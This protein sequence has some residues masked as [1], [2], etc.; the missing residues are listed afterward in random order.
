MTSIS[1]IAK[2]DANITEKKEFSPRWVH[3]LDPDQDKTAL[4]KEATDPHPRGRLANFRLEALQ[5]MMEIDLS[6]SENKTLLEIFDEFQS[7]SVDNLHLCMMLSLDQD[8][9]A[10]PKYQNSFRKKCIE[11]AELIRRDELFKTLKINHEKIKSCAD[12]KRTLQVLLNLCNFSGDLQQK[13]TAKVNLWSKLLDS[14]KYLHKAHSSFS[15]KSTPEDMKG[16]SL[17]PVF[18]TIESCAAAEFMTEEETIHFLIHY[19]Q[20]LEP[21]YESETNLQKEFFKKIRL[22][23]L[24]IQKAITSN[25]NPSKFRRTALALIQEKQAELEQLAF[26]CE[27]MIRK[28]HTLPE[29]EQIRQL[30][31]IAVVHE[32]HSHVNRLCA[33]LECLIEKQRNFLIGNRLCTNLQVCLQIPKEIEMIAKKAPPSYQKQMRNEFLELAKKMEPSFELYE[34]EEFDGIELICKRFKKS[35]HAPRFLSQFESLYAKY[36]EITK[37]LSQ[38]KNDIHAMQLKNVYT[39]LCKAL[40]P[41]FFVIKDVRNFRDTNLNDP[42]EVVPEEIIELFELE[43]DPVSNDP[44][45]EPI[46]LQ[47]PPVGAISTSV[48]EASSADESSDE[49]E[50]ISPI[51]DRSPST[52]V[53]LA[54]PPRPSQEQRQQ[55]QPQRV[56]IEREV[57]LPKFHRGMKLRKLK[58]E[59]QEM[60]SLGE[61][62]KHSGIFNSKGKFVSAVS[63]SS[64]GDKRGIPIGTLKAIQQQLQPDS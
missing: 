10:A 40:L 52:T 41:L 34:T 17:K 30:G 59:I 56:E 18:A 28:I 45:P 3:L 60:F 29:E 54:P 49:E 46:V 5:E 51:P 64:K 48:E 58:R 39:N 15:K 37:K 6:P 4:F 32:L 11:F 23:L 20:L 36:S 13:V 44:S 27:G 22:I 19:S 16:K 1:S 33:S 12:F 9:A 21:H 43:D 50:E 26:G 24:E 61:R 55:M 63:R 53:A 42:F 62:S 38:E 14:D 47:S 57:Q 31:L 7:P 35:P 8:F 25:Q 2:Q